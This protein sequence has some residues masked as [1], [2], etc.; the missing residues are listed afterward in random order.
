MMVK[1]G[2]SRAHQADDQDLIGCVQLE[3]G[4]ETEEGTQND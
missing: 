3:V 1:S 4:A 2:H